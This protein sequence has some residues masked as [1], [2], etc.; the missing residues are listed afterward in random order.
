MS[1][2]RLKRAYDEPADNDGHR[3]LVDGMW[4]RGVAKADAQIDLWLKAIAPSSGLRKW[5]G[6]DPEKW[7]EFRRR[8]DEE[9]SVGEQAQAFEQLRGLYERGRVTLVFA[10]KDR[11]HNNAVALKQRLQTGD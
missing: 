10:A 3:V 1:D 8:Y 11:E 9:L 7:D 4:P 6:H 5:F 2:V